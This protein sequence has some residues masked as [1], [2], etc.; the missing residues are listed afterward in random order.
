MLAP[1]SYGSEE[2][3]TKNQRTKCDKMS[4]SNKSTG[5]Y[6]NKVVLPA[7]CVCCVINYSV[8]LTLCSEH[9][10]DRSAHLFQNKSRRQAIHHFELIR[11]TW[12]NFKSIVLH[13][14]DGDF[15]HVFNLHD[16]NAFHAFR[17][18]GTQEF[19]LCCRRC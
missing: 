2:H 17:I 10:I 19:G 1:M 4:R 3:A 6:D 11:L 9:T 14:F 8:E 16:R 7:C 12:T 13:S 18:K 15:N 5:Y